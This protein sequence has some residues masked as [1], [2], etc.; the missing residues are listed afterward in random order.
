[1]DRDDLFTHIHKA[2]RKGLFDLAV[3][4]GATDW[5]DP[6]DIRSLADRWQ[7]IVTLLASH[8]HHEDSHILRVLDGHETD[9]TALAAEQHRRLD[10]LLRELDVR[11]TDATARPSPEAG[12]TLYRDLVQFIA[13]YLPHLHHEEAVIM[14]Q[15]WERCSDDEIAA[16]RAAFMAEVTPDEAAL[17]MELMLP[18]LDRTTRAALVAKVAATAPPAVVDRTLAIAERVLPAADADALRAAAGI[19]VG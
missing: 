5:T 14:P 1:M 12:L 8:A 4:A 10:E 18:A 11:F 3:H 15:I 9:S 19:H 13:A 6:V 7:P 17:S 16:T 2:L